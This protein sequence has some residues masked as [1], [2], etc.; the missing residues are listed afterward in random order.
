MSELHDTINELLEENGLP[1]N[2]SNRLL[3]AVL[4]EIRIAVNK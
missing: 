2:I 4:L 3:M 1:H